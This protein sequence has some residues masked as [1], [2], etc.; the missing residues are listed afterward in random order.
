MEDK[1]IP[2]DGNKVA[3]TSQ[4]ISDKSQQT[5]DSTINEIAEKLAQNSGVVQNN[6]SENNG[7]ESD[8][9]IHD[10]AK[11]L[12]QDSA[13]EKNNVPEN[14]NRTSD[15]TTT[16]IS[17]KDTGKSA[18]N[19]QDLGATLVKKGVISNDQLEVAKKQFKMYPNTSLGDILVSMGFLTEGTLGE[20]I[21]D[22]SGIKKFD[23][24]S[25]VLDSSLIRR[26]PRNVA[27]KYRIIVVKLK[28]KKVFVAIHDVY[29][30]I[31]IDIV[32]KYFPPH[33]SIEP[34][35]SPS[36]A[37]LEVINQYYDYEMSLDGVLKE[38][39][40]SKENIKT[41]DKEDEGYQNPIVR[42]VDSF[43]IDAVRSGASDIHFEP[44]ESFLRVRYRI[45][46]YMKQI[47]TFH[48]DYWPPVVVRLKIMSSM[49]IAETRVPQ[50]GHVTCNILGRDVDFRMATQPTINGENVVMRILDKTKSLRSLDKLG[51]SKHNIIV[52]KKILKKP[53]GVIIIT[54]P[55]GSGKTTS[56]YS[57]FTIY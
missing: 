3:T 39:E 35:Y 14:I 5:G 20:A 46:G 16:H 6:I 51:F 18:K 23:L 50:D 42:L 2:K 56:L 28:D 47:K 12:A 40:G 44:E 57:I 48:I 8:S 11:K 38:I 53:E 55:T 52:L 30:I 26:I 32:K 45:D 10:I 49:N 22:T 37:I 19:I 4:N 13:T 21:S 36:A 33:Y 54:G 34:V 43:L 29:D 31:A 1:R 7:K 27:T 17:I 25:A 41:S 24:K 15:V 9:T